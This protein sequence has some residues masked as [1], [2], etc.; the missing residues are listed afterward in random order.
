MFNQ[1]K[2]TGKAQWAGFPCKRQIIL[3]DTISNHFAVSHASHSL[4]TFK[5]DRKIQC[6][7]RRLAA[8]STPRSRGFRDMDPAMPHTTSANHILP[9]GFTPDMREDLF[10]IF[11]LTS[12][13][14]GRIGQT[15]LGKTDTIHT[16]CQ[17]LNDLLLILIS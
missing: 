2:R 6:F 10:L 3:A 12:P 17:S 9:G 15:I 7:K 16:P 5:G 4:L 8:K 1:N 11:E 14:I 13:V